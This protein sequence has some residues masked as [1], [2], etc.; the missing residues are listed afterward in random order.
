MFHT[1]QNVM[2]WGEPKCLHYINLGVEVILMMLGWRTF[3]RTPYGFRYA[4]LKSK[5]WQKPTPRELPKRPLSHSESA[6]NEKSDLPLR[7]V[8]VPKRA[9]RVPETRNTKKAIQ[10]LHRDDTGDNTR[11]LP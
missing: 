11:P 2:A 5:K 3:F 1:A 10:R 8:R 9:E 7:D 6:R 4:L